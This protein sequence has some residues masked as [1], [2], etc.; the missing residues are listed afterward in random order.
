MIDINWPKCKIQTQVMKLFKRFK[1]ISIL[2]TPAQTDY[3]P[4]QF[5]F[6]LFLF[7]TLSLFSL[8]PRCP[9][10]FS[11][12]LVSLF[13]YFVSYQPIPVHF[14]LSSPSF[15]FRF[16]PLYCL[17]LWPNRDILIKRPNLGSVSFPS[18]FVNWTTSIIQV[19]FHQS[20]A[21]L[22]LNSIKL[23]RFTSAQ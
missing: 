1:P 10:W 4:S 20:I 7:L 13:F 23:I 12:S 8:L 5:Y 19:K 22:S 16:L 11:P 6:V 18:K 2:V 15:H 9:I 17:Q 3:V 14:F 21:Q